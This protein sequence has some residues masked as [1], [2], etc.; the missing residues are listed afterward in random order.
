MA[1]RKAPD[2]TYT[3]YRNRKNERF[4]IDL[5]TSMLDRLSLRNVLVISA[6]Y[7]AI[8]SVSLMFSSE[9]V[10]LEV[11]NIKEKAIGEWLFFIYSR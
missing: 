11:S 9:S 2:I 6:S 1:P 4:M 10:G 3:T 5:N 7:A 8:C